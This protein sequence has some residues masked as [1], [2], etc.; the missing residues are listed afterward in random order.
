MSIWNGSPNFWRSLCRFS[1]L[2]V[3]N[4]IIVFRPSY[5]VQW[6]SR[7]VH[8]E[9]VNNVSCYLSRSML[10]L[11]MVQGRP[12]SSLVP[13]TQNQS[14]ALPRPLTL[15]TVTSGYRYIYFPRVAANCGSTDTASAYV[16]E[17]KLGELKRSIRSS[18]KP[19]TSLIRGVLRKQSVETK[20]QLV[21]PSQVLT[22][23]EPNNAYVPGREG[24][25]VLPADTSWK[26]NLSVITLHQHYPILQKSCGLETQWMLSRQFQPVCACD[27]YLPAGTKL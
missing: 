19:I 18:H 7:K 25:K 23:T 3:V 15:M 26:R 16:F 20:R 8:L 12:S 27:L 17:N 5:W 11:A 6:V 13:I 22:T 2:D 21:P 24:W 14:Q 10:P 1:L 9:N 4:V